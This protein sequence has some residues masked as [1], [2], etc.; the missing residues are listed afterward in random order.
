MKNVCCDK[1]EQRSAITSKRYEIGCQLV[2]ITNRKL[3]K[4]FL[5]VPISVISNDLERSNSPY[6]AL[7]NRIRQFCRP[8]YVK[9]VEDRPILSAEHRLPLLAKTDPPCSTVTLR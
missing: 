7:F 4:G 1:V 9:A 2:L 8:F 6:F 3:H 5:L